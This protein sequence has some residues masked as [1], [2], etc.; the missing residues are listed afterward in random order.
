M[1][2]GFP[3]RTMPKQ[4]AGEDDGWR[5]SRPALAEELLMQYEMVPAPLLPT[6]AA[7][8]GIGTDSHGAIDFLH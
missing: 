1:D 8:P 6:L 4:N 5:K 3:T 2:D 7:C